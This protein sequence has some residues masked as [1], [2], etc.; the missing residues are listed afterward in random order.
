MGKIQ[1][2]VETCPGKIHFHVRCFLHRFKMLLSYV[3]PSTVSSFSLF[4]SSFLLTIALFHF[5]PTCPPL[6]SSFI[7]PLLPSLLLWPLP[8]F[9]RA[10]SLFLIRNFVNCSLEGGVGLVSY[11][12]FLFLPE[13]RR[14]K[15]N[16]SKTNR[17][18][19][20]KMKRYFSNGMLGAL[21][22]FG[23]L[24]IAPFLHCQSCFHFF[25]KFV[26]R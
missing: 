22:V 23:D 2:F 19:L 26:N 1:V 15:R 13:K 16:S 6:R 20:K 12:I 25:I 17:E 8:R 7:V 10:F 11:L 24:C 3:I 4:P 5:I 21:D 14:Y 18:I 9:P